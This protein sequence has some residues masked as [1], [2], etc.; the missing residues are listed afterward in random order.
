MG[1]LVSSVVSRSAKVSF[2]AVVGK[3]NGNDI[4]AMIYCKCGLLSAKCSRVCI[5]F[6]SDTHTYLQKISGRMAWQSVIQGVLGDIF[7]ARER[8]FS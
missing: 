5:R 2:S 4:T 8:H 7:M 1:L 6:C 3:T